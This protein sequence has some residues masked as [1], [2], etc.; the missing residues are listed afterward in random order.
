M[1]ENV[2]IVQGDIY[3]QF[4]QVRMVIGAATG[5]LVE[6]ASLG[7]PVVNIVNKTHFP[8]MYFPDFGK[9]VLWDTAA[10]N[11]ELS[12]LIEKFDY[13]LKNEEV[14][15]TESA[16]KMKEMFFCEPTEEKI[17]EAFDIV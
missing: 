2:H 17:I 7:I 15:L 11:A 1:N 12:R 3:S 6:A 5:A 9:G 8:Q 14:K 16:V 13:T 10:T 4:E